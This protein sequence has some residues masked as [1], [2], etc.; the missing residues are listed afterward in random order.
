MSEERKV[1]KVEVVPELKSLF[2]KS[3]KKTGLTTG[4][5]KWMTFAEKDKVNEKDKKFEWIE[6]D[7]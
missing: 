2:I 5:K 4:S 1:E 6:M 7:D 3:H